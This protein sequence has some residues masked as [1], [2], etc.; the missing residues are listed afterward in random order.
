MIVSRRGNMSLKE[1]IELNVRLD[2]EDLAIIRDAF[3]QLPDL[4]SDTRNKIVSI[5]CKLNCEDLESIRESFENSDPMLWDSQ[6]REKIDA[7]LSDCYK[8]KRTGEY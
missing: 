1:K 8:I 3:K 4:P 7:A 2:P 5:T 6:T